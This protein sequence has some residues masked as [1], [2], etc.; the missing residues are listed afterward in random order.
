[1]DYDHPTPN[2]LYLDIFSMY[3]SEQIVNLLAVCTVFAVFDGHRSWTAD[4]EFHK[5]LKI[6]DPLKSS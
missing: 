4:H 1:M 3:I 6:W 5:P 2:I